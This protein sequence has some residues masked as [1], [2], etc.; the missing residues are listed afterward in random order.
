MPPQIPNGSRRSS[1]YSAHGSRTGQPAH[2]RLAS[3][4]CSELPPW[5]GKN[6]AVSMPRHAASWRHETSN[7]PPP[8]SDLTECASRYTVIG[9][10]HDKDY[11]TPADAI[12][13]L[14]LEGDT[15]SD[16]SIANAI[17]WAA[18]ALEVMI[19]EALR[20]LLFHGPRDDLADAIEAALH[21]FTESQ[22]EAA[23]QNLIR[24]ATEDPGHE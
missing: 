22:I 17:N 4:D 15:C 8:Y 10:D 2:T 18:E 7:T 24:A 13:L 21:K 20:R 16:E 12:M 14:R 19:V 3:R 9:V 1:A 23:G 5:T 11:L 6:N